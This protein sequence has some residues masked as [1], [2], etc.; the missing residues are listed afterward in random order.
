MSTPEPDWKEKYEKEVVAHKNT[1]D[2]AN[3]KIEMWINHALTIVR[4]LEF[5]LA[6]K[7]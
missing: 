1:T 7:V 4:A 6:L 3:A 2:E 5:I